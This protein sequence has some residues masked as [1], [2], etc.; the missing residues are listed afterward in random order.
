[1]S[2]N[3]KADEKQEEK[4][5][6][7]KWG[8][9]DW[10]RDSLSATIWALVLIMAGVVFLIVS[11]DLAA[12]RWLSWDRAWGAIM[13]GAALLIFLAGQRYFIRGVELQFYK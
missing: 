5:A 8:E 2:Q 4:S 6:E 1:M 9:K 7:E 13:I 3:E 11:L 10:R 12:F